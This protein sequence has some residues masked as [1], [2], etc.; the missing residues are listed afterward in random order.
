MISESDAISDEDPADR[1]EGS[2]ADRSGEARGQVAAEAAL[3]RQFPSVLRISSAE[4]VS[5]A[6]VGDG[7]DRERDDGDM[8]DPSSL[9]L[10]RMVLSFIEEGNEKPPRSRCNCFNGNCDDSSDDESDIRAGDAPAASGDAVEI[11]KVAI[12]LSY[13]LRSPLFQHDRPVILIIS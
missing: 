3:E 4:K 5:V 2:G 10:D 11:L 6:G 1:A 9:C 8:V 12:I 13:L 7:K